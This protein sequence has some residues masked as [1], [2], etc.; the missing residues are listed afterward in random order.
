MPPGPISMG[1]PLMPLNNKA[2]G[3]LTVYGVIF[4]HSLTPLPCFTLFTNTYFLDG[5]L[6][7]FQNFSKF[8][9]SI[10]SLILWF[11]S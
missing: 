4:Q 10:I 1:F 8:L 11:I 7:V 5:Y 3:P 2:L 6:G 9:N